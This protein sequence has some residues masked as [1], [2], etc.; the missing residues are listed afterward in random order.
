MK[1]IKH[2]KRFTSLSFALIMCLACQKDYLN[3][4]QQPTAET[5]IQELIKRNGNYAEI[6]IDAHIDEDSEIMRSIRFNVVERAGY[7]G[8]KDP[9]ITDDIYE[10]EFRPSIGIQKND[11]IKGVLILAKKGDIKSVY[12]QYI[13]FTAVAEQVT[14]TEKLVLRYIGPI[15]MP[16]GYK[17]NQGDEWYSMAILNFDFSTTDNNRGLGESIHGRHNHGTHLNDNQKNRGTADMLPDA[18]TSFYMPS[19]PLLSNWKKLEI[20]TDGHGRALDFTFKPQGALVQYDLGIDVA[21]LQEIRHFGLVTN[22]LDL[23]GSYNLES[24]DLLNKLDNTDSNGWGG[25]PTWKADPPHMDSYNL[26][27]KNLSDLGLASSE[28]SFP[29]HLPVLTNDPQGDEIATAYGSSPVNKAGMSVR[30][31]QLYPHTNGNYPLI[32]QWTTQTFDNGNIHWNNVTLSGGTE[33][34]RK[35][36]NRRMFLFW[37]MPRTMQAGEQ[38]QSYFYMDF[39]DERDKFITNFNYNDFSQL[40]NR[41]IQYRNDMY[42]LS[43][44]DQHTEAHNY[45]LR[46]KAEFDRYKVDSLKF[47]WGLMPRYISQTQARTQKSI[48]LHQTNA[49]FKANRISHIQTLLKSDLL[50]TEQTH[51]TRGGHNYSMLEIHNPTKKHISLADYA[52]VRLIDNGQYMSY[53]KADG[54]STDKLSEALILPLSVVQDNNST[55]FDNSGF[56]NWSGTRGSYDKPDNRRHKVVYINGTITF[57]V[58]GGDDHG[59][60]YVINSSEDMRLAPDQTI[61]LGASGY[62]QKNGDRYKY[63]TNGIENDYLAYIRF[64]TNQFICRYMLAYSDATTQDYQGGTLDFE[65]GEGF[66]LIKNTGNGQW[67][68][69]D[70]TAP[71]GPSGLAFPTSYDVYKKQFAGMGSNRVYT[72]QRTDGIDFP[73]LYPFRT[74]ANPSANWPSNHWSFDQD[75]SD[76]SRHG[77][78]GRRSRWTSQQLRF[79]Q[80]YFSLKRTP[81]D[82]NYPT[83]KQNIPVK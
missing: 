38:P 34:T 58:T 61:L 9:S 72:I 54:T 6:S 49:Q 32:G 62:L 45:Y 68:I 41:I 24:Q 27:Y 69:I 66:A 36:Q 39:H 56:S 51:L 53:R 16:N 42:D 52:V 17:F 75:F 1:T 83:Y 3:E 7:P 67:Q 60:N 47:Y 10:T 11:K 12:R 76:A 43:L 28:V 18:T 59:T 78:P 33:N 23:S 64:N 29:W 46:H 21:D 19:I 26:Y 25:F 82:P 14:G 81:L 8:R 65:P 31:I 44:I 4:P 22:T 70:A 50:I 74:K 79:S 80:S 57:R 15:H 5:N 13:T 35:T 20:S 63:E 77:S 48:I 30:E 73:Y 2:L 55:P 37:G 40:E 71:I